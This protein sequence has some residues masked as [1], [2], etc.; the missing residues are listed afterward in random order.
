M[1]KTALDTSFILRLLTGS[2]PKQFVLARQKVDETLDQRRA[3]IVSDLVIA[4]TYFALQ[5]HFEVPK[6]EAL[7]QI[8]AFLLSGIVESSS[9]SVCFYVIQN[10]HSYKAGFVDQLICGQFLSSCEEIFSF[11]QALA[12]L[13][14]V[15]ILK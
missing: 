2:P 10:V 12:A 14:R 9:G 3:L 7:E 6:K 13:P 5:Y 4:E 11:D 8:R 1:G 15:T